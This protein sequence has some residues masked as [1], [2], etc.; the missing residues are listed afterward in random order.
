MIKRG[1]PAKNG[2]VEFTF[3]VPVD[4][5]P[6]GLSLVGDF[7]DWDPYAHPMRQED[8]VYHVTIAVPADRSICFRYLGDGGVWF[9]DADADRHD[10]EGGHLDPARSEVSNVNGR[11]APVSAS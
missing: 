1:R 3:T 8:D 5:A 2:L 9:D 7:N 6:A 4:Q 11:T 10:R